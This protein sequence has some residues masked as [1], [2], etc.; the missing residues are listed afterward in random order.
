[1]NLN[2][3]TPISWQAAALVLA[4]CLLGVL[5]YL[6]VEIRNELAEMRH[7]V[8]RIQRNDSVQDQRLETL[9]AWLW[10]RSERAGGTRR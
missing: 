1:M 9:E 10:R 3:N 5:L 8:N 6:G 4:N 2:G 7:E